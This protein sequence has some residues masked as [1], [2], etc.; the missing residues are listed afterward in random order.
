MKHLLDID[1]DVILQKDLFWIYDYYAMLM[2]TSTYVFI[3]VI[4]E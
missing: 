4:Y 3:I 1:F 2:I